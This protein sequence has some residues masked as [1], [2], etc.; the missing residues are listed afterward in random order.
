MV[1]DNHALPPPTL[2]SSRSI[3]CLSVE[4]GSGRRP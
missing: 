4:L 1:A 3:R 2:H